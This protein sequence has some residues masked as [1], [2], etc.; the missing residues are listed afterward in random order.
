MRRPRGQGLLG[1]AIGITTLLLLAACGGSSD[2]AAPTPEPTVAIAEAP[3]ATAAPA[4]PTATPEPTVA[5]T[6]TPEPTAAPELTV[7]EQVIAAWKRYLDLSIQARGKE[8]TGEALDIASYATDGARTVLED[9]LVQQVE[10]GRYIEGSV[11]SL[12]PTVVLEGD[13]EARLEDCVAVELLTFNTADEVTLE[14]SER[15][16]TEVRLSLEE[17]GWRV[18]ALET[19]EPCGA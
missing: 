12:A 7:E 15:R 17:T 13:V 1:G 14:S 19:G 6:A 3:T 8:P 5:P 16:I 4:E 18:A 11:A 10:E 9:L 2:V